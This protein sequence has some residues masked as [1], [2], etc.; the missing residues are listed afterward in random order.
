MSDLQPSVSHSRAAMFSTAFGKVKRG[1]TR[2]LELLFVGAHLFV[3]GSTKALR[4][5]VG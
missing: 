1:V 4:K 2:D 3:S 5:N